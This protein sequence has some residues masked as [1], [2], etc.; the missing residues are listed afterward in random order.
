M[1]TVNNYLLDKK[2][3]EDESKKEELLN[4][5]H[6]NFSIFNFLPLIDEAEILKN[7]LK[8]LHINEAKHS[9]L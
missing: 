3:K 1:M 4:K 7:H 2:I 5:F 9:N 6:N 8:A